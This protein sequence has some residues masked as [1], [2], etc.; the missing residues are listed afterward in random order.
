MSSLVA[1]AQYWKSRLAIVATR[2]GDG[3]DIA[4]HV[5]GTILRVVQ[6]AALAVFVIHLAGNAIG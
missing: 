4:I 1:N 6:I 5:K 3:T 2:P